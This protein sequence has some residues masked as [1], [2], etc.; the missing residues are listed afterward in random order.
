MSE[1]GN[2]TDDTR[3]GEADERCDDQD[4]RD[5]GTVDG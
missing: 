5:A 3:D 1:I 4:G 2:Q